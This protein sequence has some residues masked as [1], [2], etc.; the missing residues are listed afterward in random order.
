MVQTLIDVSALFAEPAAVAESWIQIMKT[1]EWDHPELGK[2]KIT[3]SDLTKFKENFDNRVRGV[4]LFV[5]IS[6][7]PEGGAVATFKELKVDGDK[8]M[9]QVGWT[10]EGADLIKSGKYRYFSPEFKF[11]WKDPE[12]GQSYKDVLFGGALTNR[13]FLKGMEPVELS[14]TP[15]PDAILW[16]AEDDDP[17]GD[18]DD[19]TTSDPDKNP[20]WESDVRK[21]ILPWSKLSKDQ[22][23]GLTAKGFTAEHAAKANKRAK[24]MMA[25]DNVTNARKSPPKGWPTDKSLYADPDHFKY[26][27]DGPGHIQSAMGYYNVAVNKSKGGYNDA[28]WDAMGR[29]IVAAANKEFGSGHSLKDGKILTPSTKM[30]DPDTRLNPNDGSQ[31]T[32]PIVDDDAGKFTETKGGK[33]MS[34]E[35]VSLAEFQ[36]AQAKI[37]LLE[38]QARQTKFADMVKGYMFDESA[39]V[40]RILP[41]QKDATVAFMMSLNDEQVAKFDELVKGLPGAVQFGEVGMVLGDQPKDAKTQADAIVTLAEK[42]VAEEHITFKEAYARAGRELG[43]E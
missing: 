1:G 13:P 34:E 11:S 19:D 39:K 43:V 40:A 32:H 37:T 9:A 8:L 25:E 15:D 21:G 42:K 29:K 7:K 24:V 38:T 5:D 30:D 28:Q 14:E 23:D 3:P 10:E 27:L 6:H 12:G 33:G 41:A 35:T 26:R 4:D 22:Q 18:G 31:Q 36:A 20:D 16:F 17:D 2:L